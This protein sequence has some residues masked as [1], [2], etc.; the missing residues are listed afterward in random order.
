MAVA[1]LIYEISYHIK[2]K[3]PNELLQISI[4]LLE[5]ER[6]REQ[7]NEHNWFGVGNNTA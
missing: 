1:C 6:N 4:L 3:F 5:I 2:Y 7:N